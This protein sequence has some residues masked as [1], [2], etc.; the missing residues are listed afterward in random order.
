MKTHYIAIMVFC[1]LL[2][3][4]TAAEPETL[5]PSEGGQDVPSVAEG[6]RVVDYSVAGGLH[7]KALGENLPANERISSLKY[8]LYDSVKA[9]KGCSE[10]SERTGRESG[11]LLEEGYRLIDHLLEKE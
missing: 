3:A 4:C 5:S 1:S 2:A 6:M 11:R 7:S 10:Y 9:Q 8:L